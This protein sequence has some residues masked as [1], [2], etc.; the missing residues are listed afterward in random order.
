MVPVNPCRSIGPSVQIAGLRLQSRAGALRPDR[1]VE[2][3]VYLVERLAALRGYQ[4]HVVA[5]TKRRGD[6]E[7]LDIVVDAREDHVFSGLQ[8]WAA[9]NVRTAQMVAGLDQEGVAVEPGYLATFIYRPGR[10]LEGPVVLRL[11]AD[12][13]RPEH[14]SFLFATPPEDRLLIDAAD[15]VIPVVPGARRR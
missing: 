3:D 4:L 1:L 13:L 9:F 6:L 11:L 12:P 5:D 8:Y 10:D 15:L 7:L 2:V 14:R